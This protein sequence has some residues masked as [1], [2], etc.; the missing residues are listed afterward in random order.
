MNVTINGKTMTELQ[1]INLAYAD[2]TNQDALNEEYIAELFR[3]YRDN[4]K[5]FQSKPKTTIEKILNFFAGFVEAITGSV[6]RSPLRVLEEID[7]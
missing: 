5:D 3:L 1:R 6:F 4:P 7:N 2:L